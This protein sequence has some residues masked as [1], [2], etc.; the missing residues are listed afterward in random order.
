R[1]WWH[2]RLAG[3]PRAPE[4][5]TTVPLT[6]P[7][8]AGDTA[9]THARRLHHWVAPERK[10]ALAARA[11]QYGLTPAA[12][13]ATAF[14]EVL[15]A[16]SGNRRFLLNLPLFD[17]ELFTPDVASLVGDF[18]SS[19]L[20]DVDLTA[21]ASF[22]AH[23]R[24]VQDG[25]RAGVAH[26]A[27]GGVEV[28]RDLT[29]AEGSPVLAPVVYT[30]A[31]GL[32]EIFTPGVQEVFGRPVWIISQ[33]PQ[34]VLDAQVTELD[35]GLLLNWDVRDGVLAPGVPDAAFAAYRALLTSLTEDESAWER[36]VGPLVPA[37]VLAAREAAAP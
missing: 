23:A 17:R 9:L 35:G 36:P 32:G 1:A 27:Y 3:L 30:S 37:A 20:L 33:G 29:R 6:R 28:L 16:W 25:I 24:R 15:A 5:P 13:L 26:G 18:S 4:P 11:G 19:L 2:E 31:L 8:A 34:V 12:A 22:L 21:S 7:V 10:D 14:A